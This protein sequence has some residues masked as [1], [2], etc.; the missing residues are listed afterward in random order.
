MGPATRGRNAEAFQ[1]LL[2][3]VLEVDETSPIA[4]ALAQ[5]GVT[6]ITQLLTY[7]EA[8]MCAL[9]YIPAGKADPVTLF[10]SHAKELFQAI[11]YYQSMPGPGNLEDWFLLSSATFAGWLSNPDYYAQRAAKDAANTAAAEDDDDAVSD[12]EDPAELPEVTPAPQPVTVTTTLSA[13]ANFQRS[14]R[15]VPSDFPCF[16]EG[17]RL[18]LLEQKL[19]CYCYCTSCAIELQPGLFSHY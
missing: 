6:R 14:I 16:Q 2:V 9:T 15:R 5:A 13:A 12:F 3:E 17:L 10:P 1:H 8:S 7:T 18:G 4:L 11:A 19:A